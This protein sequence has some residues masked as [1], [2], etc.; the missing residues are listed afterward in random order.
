[1][2]RITVCLACVMVLAGSLLATAQPSETA[3]FKTVEGGHFK[4]D[5]RHARIVFSTT[6]LGFSTYYGFFGDLDGKLD[7][8]PASP[9]ASTL[10]VSVNLDG[11]VTNDS[12]LDDN[13]KSPDYFDVPKFPVATFK[14]TK[15]EVTGA[16]TGRITGDLTLH[17]VTKPVVLDAILNRGGVNPVTKD[18]ILGFDATGTLSRSEF[19]IKTLVP[20]VGDQVKLTLSCEFNRVK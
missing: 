17:G 13:L 20:F 14:S 11:L 3:D 9:T 10:E 12:E 1:V 6:H 19:G 16:A 4:L 15:I 8:D 5:K 7:Y 18:Y 2:T